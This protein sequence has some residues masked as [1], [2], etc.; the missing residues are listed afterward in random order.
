MN[1][2]AIN[3][4]VKQLK[5]ESCFSRVCMV[6][7]LKAV[8]FKTNF[9]LNFKFLFVFFSYLGSLSQLLANHKTVDERGEHFFNT[10]LPLPPVSQTLRY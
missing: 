9:N 10:S 3:E 2:T 6:L 1:K 4:N 5:S 8:P 7:Y